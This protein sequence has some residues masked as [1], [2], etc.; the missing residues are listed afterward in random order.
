MPINNDIEPSRIAHL[1]F[2]QGAINRMGNN[3]FLL[4]GWTITIIAALFA[5]SAK[6]TKVEFIYITYLPTFVFWVLDAYFLHYERLFRKLYDQIAVDTQYIPNYSMSTKQLN[7]TPWK[8]LWLCFSS[9]TLLAFYLPI[10]FI[11]AF[12]HI[13]LLCFNS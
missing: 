8:N 3:S 13:R 5:L 7:V 11:L 4:K 6:D 9:N 1:G 10:V 12:V 2:I